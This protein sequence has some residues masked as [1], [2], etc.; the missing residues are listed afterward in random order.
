M[1]LSKET[2]D[3]LKNFSTI[4]PSIAISAGDSLSTMSNCKNSIAFSQVKETFPQD[5]AFYDLPEFLS[6]LDLFEEPELDFKENKVN[7]KSG[8]SKCTYVYC[9]R[10]LIEYP[11]KSVS[12][13]PVVV[14]FKVTEAQISKLLKASATLGLGYIKV[15]KESESNKILCSVVDIK[16]PSSNSFELNVGEEE[17]SA[18]YAYY[19]NT[20]HLHLQKSDYTIK[21]AAQPI[22]M[23][24]SKDQVEYFV[25]LEKQ[26]SY[27]A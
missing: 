24:Q 6:V 18:Q 21:F 25:A 17:S 1:K 11:K 15:S 22:S 3:L 5:C 16:D 23:F 8:N 27:T 2:M 14:E 10:N 7:I 19:I 12:M 9:E 26:S 13:P 4:N 20:N